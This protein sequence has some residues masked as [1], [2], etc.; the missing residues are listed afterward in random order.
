VGM[1][2]FYSAG[3]KTTEEENLKVIAHAAELGI[4]MLDTAGTAQHGCL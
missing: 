1:S 2:A 4:T 3:G